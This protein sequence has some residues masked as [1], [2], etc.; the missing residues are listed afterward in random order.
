MIVAVG[1]SRCFTK[2]SS[3]CLA[4]HTPN[5]GVLVAVG[6]MILR[7]KSKK[8]IPS[9]L[10]RL[11]GSGFIVAAFLDS[12]EDNAKLTGSRLFR[13]SSA[14]PGYGS[15]GGSELK[16]K[17][18]CIWANRIPHCEFGSCIHSVPHDKDHDCTKWGDCETAIGTKKA[19][20]T[21]VSKSNVPGS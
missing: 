8:Q 16:R 17:L 15:A 21:A 1:K 3:L 7:Q 14:A 9:G 12:F 6:P 20:C 13:R 18:Q 11:M 10:N 19:R 5:C 2:A 4:T